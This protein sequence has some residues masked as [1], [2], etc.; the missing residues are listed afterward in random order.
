MRLKKRIGA[1]IALSLLS[2]VAFMSRANA[3]TCPF[4]VDV[5]DL[6]MCRFFYHYGSEQTKPDARIV[7]RLK[8]AAGDRTRSFALI[9]GISKY[10]NFLPQDQLTPATN[11]VAHLKTFL[12]DD[13]K[14]D[15][16]IVLE[17]DDATAANIS[18]FLNDY[19]LTRSSL[20]NRKSRILI[21]YSGH[22]VKQQNML[23]PSLVL[24]NATSLADV[25]NLYSLSLIRT[26]VE[27]LASA[28]FHVLALINACFGGMVFAVALGGGQPSDSYS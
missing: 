6:T 16:I 1:R 9:I 28:N 4:G 5:A 22:G 2:V 12:K 17:N 27:N 13:Q 19:L 20:Y 15:E 25:S 14:F 8:L 23:P 24:S 21:A 3:P 26:S 7:G 11:D 10:P 18:Y